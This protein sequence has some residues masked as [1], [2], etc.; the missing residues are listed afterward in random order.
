M[1]DIT[2]FNEQDLP[3]DVRANIRAAA[4]RIRVRLKRSGEDIIEIGKDLL[5]VKAQLAHGQFGPW[6]QREFELSERTA[7]KLMDVAKRFGDRSAH[8]ADF[9]PAILYALS[10]PSTPES[11]RE[12]AIEMAQA[13]QTVT[14]ADVEALK[15]EAQMEKD[16]RQQ[17][18]AKL[19]QVQK[20]NQILHANLAAASEREQRSY[21]ELVETQEQIA[22][23]AD[24]KSKAAIEQARQEAQAAQQRVDALRKELEHRERQKA[25]AIRE[26]IQNG[27]AGR[28]AEVDSLNRAIQAAEAEL[29]D[30][31]QRLKE[32]TGAE[33]ENQRLHIDAEKALRELMVLGTTL[34][35]FECAV[36]YPVNGELLDRLTQVA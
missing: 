15:R 9:K 19:E 28:Q 20:Q 31:R 35:L 13:G 11:V 34:N 8:C 30:Y 27:L 29:T 21:R 24:E 22:S 16:T 17:L 18:S 3:E 7:Q 23:L 5:G 1:N 2:V 25:Y 6:L 14:L 26:G 10:A 36:I 33:H 4:E 12:A 32:R